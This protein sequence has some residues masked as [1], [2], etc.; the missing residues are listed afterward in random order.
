MD[1][2]KWSQLKLIL[3]VIK[4]K[5]WLLIC[6]LIDW[7]ME[8]FKWSHKALLHQ[9]KEET[10]AMAGREAKAAREV[11]VTTTTTKTICST[12]NMSPLS[13]INNY[14][15][16]NHLNLNSRMRYH[17]CVPYVYL[18]KIGVIRAW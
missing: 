17:Y 18:S 1:S 5:K 8:I 4:M 10:E 3:L 12:D 14:I 13:Y 6:Y 9:I 16:I 11:R 7:Q 15:K 2:V